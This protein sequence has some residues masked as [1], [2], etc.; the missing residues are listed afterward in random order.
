[1]STTN[2]NNE[3]LLR[4][5]RALLRQAENTPYEEEAISFLEKA[6][7]LMLAYAIDEETLWASEPDKRPKPI[8]HTITIPSNKTGAQYQRVILNGICKANRCKMWFT[9]D[10][11]SIAGYENDVLL[12]EMLFTSVKVQMNLQLAKAIVSSGITGQKIKTFRANFLEAYG[13]RIYHR[14]KEIQERATATN[15]PTGQELVLHRSASVE[16]FV[17][18]LN[19]RLRSSKTTSTKN[20]DHNAQRAGKNA[21]DKTDISAGRNQLKNKRVLTP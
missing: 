11:C 13:N 18:G 19:L 20:Y 5:I 10:E 15:T 7:E 4:K 16:H 2:T 9:R 21:A 17:E 6:S 1:M 14:F 3:S 12:V 8:I